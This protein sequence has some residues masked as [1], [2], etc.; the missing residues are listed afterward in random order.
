MDETP[1]K[2]ILNERDEIVTCLSNIKKFKT[3]TDM[4]EDIKTDVVPVSLSDIDKVVLEKTL[5][6][7]PNTNLGSENMDMLYSL[8]V[9]SD[10]LGYPE[11]CAAIGKEIVSRIR[12]KST[13]EM[14]DILQIN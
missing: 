13:M 14:R 10:F 12:R 11:G 5:G 2:V 3:L 8:M 4:L 6:L 7:T 1:I 9:T